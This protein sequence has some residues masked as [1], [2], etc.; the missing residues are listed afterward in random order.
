LSLPDVSKLPDSV[1]LRAAEQL[2]VLKD[3]HLPDL[4]FFNSAPCPSH[5]TLKDG[6]FENPPCQQCGISLRKHQRVGVGWLYLRKYGLIADS[7]G[8]GKT[9]MAAGLLALMKQAGELDG[10]RALVVARAP[11]V[12]Q[13]YQQLQRM[14]PLLTVTTASGTVSERIEKYLQPW[15]VCLIGY[16]MLNND[17]ERLLNFNV[18]TTIVDDVDALRHSDNK[19]AYSIKRL[20]RDCDRVVILTGTPLQKKLPELHS[21]L[22]PIGG[23]ELFGSEKAFKSRYLREDYVRE[24]NPR[25]GRY[26]QK[27][28]VIGVKN[29][30]EFKSLIAPLALRRTADDI[31]DVDLPAVSV[32]N[33][34]LDLYP[35]Q[36]EKYAELRKGV[37]KIIREEGVNVKRATAGARFMYG[38]QICSGL[39]TIGE[40]DLPATSSK[41]D[42]LSEM[43]IEGDLS[44]EKVVVFINFKNTIR[45]MQKRLTQG[46][47]GHVTIWGDEPD[48]AVRWKA[49]ERFWNDP[50]CKV[51][52]G[53]TAIEQSLNLQVAR[54][55]VNVD[56]ILNPARMTQLMGRVRR[57]GSAFKTVYIHNL[58]CNGTQES[59]YLE[60]LGR[61][62]ALI[63]HVWD[64]SSDLYEA[65]SPMAMLELIGKSDAA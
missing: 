43:L 64:D 53:T 51:L 11:A 45:A 44:E 61:E 12:Q 23:R 1:R 59:G 21:V 55:L 14:L 31:D 48:K 65:L 40:D 39:A 56:Q 32:D 58:L 47:V 35:K 4:S 46:R 24:F 18:R 52:I 9:A 30:D 3:F 8:T 37:L 26:T 22:E 41:L 29:M 17:L 62:Q 13:W 2:R 49:Q 27:R 20:A 7:V 16:Q 54:H 42:W 38:S 5:E 28:T 25:T 15:D 10:R 60:L 33:V 63:D 34:Y 36:R 57:V 50:A 19:A 6:L